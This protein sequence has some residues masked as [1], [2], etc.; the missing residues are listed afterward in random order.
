MAILYEVEKVRTNDTWFD[1]ISS[2]LFGQDL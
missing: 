1:P 2:F